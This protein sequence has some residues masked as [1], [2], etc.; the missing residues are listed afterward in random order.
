MVL[1]KKTSENMPEECDIETQ[2]IT[3]KDPGN[4]EGEPTANAGDYSGA[5]EKTDPVE[6]KLVR[7]IDLRLMVR[8]TTNL[9]DYTLTLQ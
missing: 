9:I 3:F 6:V 7:K 5:S 1:D 4:M 8:S 2:S